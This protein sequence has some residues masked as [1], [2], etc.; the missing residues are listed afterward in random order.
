MLNGKLCDVPEYPN[1]TR[2][3]KTIF[4]SFYAMAAATN[5]HLHITVAPSSY[6]NSDLH[7]IVAVAPGNSPPAATIGYPYLCSLPVHTAGANQGRTPGGATNRVNYGWPPLAVVVCAHPRCSL[8]SGVLHI[9]K[10]PRVITGDDTKLTPEV[11]GTNGIPGLS[12]RFNCTWDVNLSVHSELLEA[13]VRAHPRCNLWCIL[14]I[15]NTYSVTHGE[16][17]PPAGQSQSDH[18]PLPL[19]V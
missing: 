7:I 19:Q 5:S 18:H 1:R 10:S 12:P 14:Y 13:P 3:R 4:L 8:T 11:T 16:L 2:H 9:S 17:G 6:Y 15:G